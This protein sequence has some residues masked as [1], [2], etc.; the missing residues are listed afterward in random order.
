MADC[1]NFTIN[2]TNKYMNHCLDKCIQNI[3]INNNEIYTI[4]NACYCK[5]IS[6][7]NDNN[8]GYGDSD[9]YSDGYSDNNVFTAF[10]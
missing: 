5:C 10:L 4:I 1:Y 8:D 2:E 6:K 9:G 7:L 3:D